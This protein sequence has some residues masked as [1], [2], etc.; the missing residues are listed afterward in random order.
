[1]A[2][3]AG[4]EDI[5]QP[6]TNLFVEGNLGYLLHDAHHNDEKLIVEADRIAWD[7]W[8]AEQANLRAEAA[9]QKGKSRG[10]PVNATSSQSTYEV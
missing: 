7:L 2:G 3:S 5:D 10:R 6:S 9:Q 1:M 8:Q 4:S